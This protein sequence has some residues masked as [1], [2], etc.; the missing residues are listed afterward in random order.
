MKLMR[1]LV[2]ELKTTL[3]HRPPE[4]LS[5]EVKFIL[6]SKNLLR[7]DKFSPRRK[8][9]IESDVKILSESA[10]YSEF[11]FCGK[12]VGNFSLIKFLSTCVGD[13][14]V[15]NFTCSVKT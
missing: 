1:Y 11:S 2:L 6:F 4:T 10:V 3:S 13:S 8:H 14:K 12:K 7:L 9:T 15:I 5:L